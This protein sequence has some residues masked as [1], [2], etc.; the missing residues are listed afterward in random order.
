MVVRVGEEN[1]VF[2]HQSEIVTEGDGFRSLQEQSKVEYDVS[3]EEG[4]RF[5]AG[6]SLE[7]GR[8]DQRLLVFGRPR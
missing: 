4:G 3:I 8:R 2:V 7:G 5:P 6:S 1:D